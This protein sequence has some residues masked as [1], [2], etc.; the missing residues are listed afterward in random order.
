MQSQNQFPVLH[1]GYIARGERA[2]NW[3]K[4][5]AL[6]KKAFTFLH[7]YTQ[8]FD[9]RKLILSNSFFVTVNYCRK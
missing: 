6:Q 8:P 2:T 3:I 9:K 1:A 4:D 7:R 5:V